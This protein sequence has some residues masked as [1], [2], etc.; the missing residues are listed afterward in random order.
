[1]S[2]M[3]FHTAYSSFLPH[4]QIKRIQLLHIIGALEGGRVGHGSLAHAAAHLGDRLVFVLLHP[5]LQGVQQVCQ[6][7]DEYATG[8]VTALN[9][10]GLQPF[11]YATVEERSMLEEIE[12][13]L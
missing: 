5:L 4:I 3:P 2:G 8:I 7:V 1:V 13:S 11:K 10:D 9:T 6:A 12:A